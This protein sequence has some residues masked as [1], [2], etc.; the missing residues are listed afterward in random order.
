MQEQDPDRMVRYPLTWPAWMAKV[1]AEAAG[2]RLMPM[3]VW[4]REAI[5][6]KIERERQSQQEGGQR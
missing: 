3:A 4:V 2:S 5:L 1:V 6:E